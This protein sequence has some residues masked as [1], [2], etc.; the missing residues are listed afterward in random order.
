MRTL[1]L[2]LALMSIAGAQ[3]RPVTTFDPVGKWPYST[4]DSGGNPISGTMDI[5]G[6]PGSYTGSITVGGETVIPITDVL[7]SPT[8]MA[9]FVTLPDG[10][11]G[12]VKAWKGAD[13]QMQGFW[14]PLEAQVPLTVA[15]GK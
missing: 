9:L 1:V 2:A 8:G 15:K 7:T 12:V 11:A 4:V 10:Q 3:T 13:G 5:A 14:G 6:T